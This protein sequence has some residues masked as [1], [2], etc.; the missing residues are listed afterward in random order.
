MRNGTEYGTEYGMNMKWV[1]YVGYMI[2]D[3]YIS[4]GPPNW[5]QVEM[6]DIW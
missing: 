1:Y 6:A 2:F 4:L 3:R 5:E